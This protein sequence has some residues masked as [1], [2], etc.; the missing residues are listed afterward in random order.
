MKQTIRLNTFET[1][2]SSMHSLVITKKAR[3][4]TKEELALGYDPKYEKEFDLWG[5]CDYNEMYYERGPFRILSTPLEKLRY[6]SAYVLGGYEKPKQEDIDRIINFVMKQT[7]ITDPDKIF[8][9]KTIEGKKSQRKSYGNVY[10]NDT[11]EDPMAFVKRKGIY[12]ED[13]ILNP[14]Y[15]IIIDGDEMQYFKT[16]IDAEVVN[17]DNFEDISSGI[18]FWN[19]VNQR[20]C[21]TWYSF[22][23]II[24]NYNAEEINH[25]TKTLDIVLT[26]KKDLKTYKTNLKYIK[27]AIKLSRE[28]KPD[29]KVR[30]VV[31]NDFMKDK[32]PLDLSSID[33]SIFDEV[34]NTD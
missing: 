10:S 22:E 33:T 31:D 18:D 25:K 6:Y 17:T 21:L 16:L 19:D 8:L 14:K 23:E 27:N 30:L 20:I 4:Y 3:Q 28:K 2:S 34:H 29:I 7:G 26:S 1:N 11:G 5:Y 9:F 12:W 13:L 32:K 24:K 15:T